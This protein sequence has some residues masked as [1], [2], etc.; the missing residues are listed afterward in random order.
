[1][2]G[3]SA[4]STSTISCGSAWPESGTDPSQAASTTSSSSDG[5][6]PVTLTRV[7]AGRSGPVT[8][9]TVSSSRRRPRP[10]AMGSERVATRP[11]NCSAR[12]V[13]S[14]WSDSSLRPPISL[15][16]TMR[17]GERERQKHQHLDLPDP[18]GPAPELQRER[19]GQQRRYPDPQQEEAGNDESPERAGRSR[20]PSSSTARVP[21][22]PIPACS[23]SAIVATP[24][25]TLVRRSRRRD[26]WRAGAGLP[27]TRH[28]QW[29]RC[30]PQRADQRGCLDSGITPACCCCARHLAQC[31]RVL[32]GHEIVDC[33]HVALAIASDTPAWR[34]LRPRRRVR[35]RPS[36][37]RKAASLRPSGFEDLRRL[38]AFGSSIWRACSLGHHLARHRLH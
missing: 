38:Q 11:T 20:W 23:L 7:P 18:E 8:R 3:R 17:R 15:L 2:R 31:P 33:L 25:F 34:G 1:M 13:S 16:P 37:S 10:S 28:G 36:A 32:L 27:R 14:G 6:T 22:R 9:H 12:R 4:S 21:Q 19:P 5:P 35:R 26:G 30:A 29:P 24:S